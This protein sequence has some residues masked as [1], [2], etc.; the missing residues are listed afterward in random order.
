[1]E[2]V[3][4]FLAGMG[5]GCFYFGGLWLT[6]QTLGRTARATLQKNSSLAPMLTMLLSFMVRM[7]ITLAGLY[8]LMQGSWIRVLV[9]LLGILAARF[10]IKHRVRSMAHQE[11]PE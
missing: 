1:M 9:A 11:V 8:W 10:L 6:T 2:Y 4:V 5:L 3:A 7:C